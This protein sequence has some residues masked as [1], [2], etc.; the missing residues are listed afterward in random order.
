MES[1]LVN[2]AEIETHNNDCD[3]YGCN[4]R[5]GLWK[6]SDWSEEVKLRYLCGGKEAPELRTAPAVTNPTFPTASN[7]VFKNWTADGRVL[8][9]V[10]QGRCG[11]CWAFSAAA[12]TEGVFLKTN[13][14]AKSPL[15]PQYLID[16]ET[17]D[18]TGCDGGY[19]STALKYIQNNKIPTNAKYPFKV[20]QGYCQS[21]IAKVNA[22]IY[23]ST[24]IT[25]NGNETLL[26]DI[27]STMGP[28]G[29]SIYA[30][31]AFG[32]YK[33]GIYNNLTCINSTTN[34]A[35]LLVGYGSQLSNGTMMDYWLVKNS[36]GKSWG[37]SGYVKM[38]RNGN[39]QCGIARY[40]YIAY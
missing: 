25:L 3:R 27:V 9:V 35:V 32:S 7:L 36:W 6:R 10:D 29:V 28:V 22:S 33:S 37:E 11:C 17:A 18:S 19:T 39:N 8:P 20:T 23:N 5:R 12:I 34:H 16:C 13:S 40:A 38:R 30:S 4:F 15:S 1:F 14:L 26:R 31:D 2:F 24:R 21:T